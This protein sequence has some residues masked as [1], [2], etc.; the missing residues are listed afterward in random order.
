MTLTDYASPPP[1]NKENGKCVL[2]FGGSF[3]FGEGLNDNETMPY[4]V[5]IK[6]KGKYQVYNFGFHGYGPHQ[7]LS[8]IEHNMVNDII[9]CKQKYV[10]YQA[11]VTHADRSGGFL[12]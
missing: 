11:L 7:M 5:G 10:I 3:T 4:S 12:S 1:S 2:F 9:S 6:M 8:A